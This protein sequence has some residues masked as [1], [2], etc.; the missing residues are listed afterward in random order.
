MIERLIV[1]IFEERLK[2][3]APLIQVII[4]IAII[5]WIF[6][7]SGIIIC[8]SHIIEKIGAIIAIMLASSF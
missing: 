8:D 1:R 3:V 4:A 5:I 7:I 2:V 6:I